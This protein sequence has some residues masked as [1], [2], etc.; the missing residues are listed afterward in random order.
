MLFIKLVEFL[1]N[2]HI[3]DTIY[4]LESPILRKWEVEEHADYHEI[5]QTLFENTKEK[6]FSKIVERV[7]KLK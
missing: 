4:D 6:D 7:I 2:K 5:L 1:L 3:K